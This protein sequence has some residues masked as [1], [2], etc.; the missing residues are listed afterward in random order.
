MLV[1]EIFLRNYSLFDKQLRYCIKLHDLRNQQFF[2]G[3]DL[4]IF[5][6]SRDIGSRV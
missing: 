2:L 4:G 3:D 1:E 6:D 5:K